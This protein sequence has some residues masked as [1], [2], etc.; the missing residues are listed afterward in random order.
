MTFQR[1]KWELNN[2]LC[3]TSW[4]GKGYDI[5]TLPIYR[6]LSKEHFHGKTCRKY[7]SETNF[8]ISF[9]NLLEIKLFEKRIIKNPQKA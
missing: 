4:D 6:V 7:K 5:E 3:L 1:S 8:R 9:K 2:T